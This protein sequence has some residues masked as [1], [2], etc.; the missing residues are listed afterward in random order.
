MKN[1]S[2][3]LAFVA[4]STFAGAQNI[5]HPW[6]VSAGSNF[7]DFHFVKKP[8]TEQIRDAN[9][10]GKKAPT[11]LRVGRLVKPWLSVSATY[12]TVTLEPGRLNAIPLDSVITDDYFVKAGIQAEYR[13]AN[14]SLLK[15][16]SFFDPYIFA[17]FTATWIND[18]FYPGIPM[19]FGINLWPVDFLGVNFQASYDYLFD[20]NDYAHYALG[21]TF[22]FGNMIDK[23]NDRVADRYD[24]CPEIWGLESMHG[25]PDYDHDGVVDS[26]DRC[27]KEYGSA[28]ADG[29]PD[30]DKDGI[31][32][33]E[34]ACTCEAGPKSRNGCPENM[35]PKQE[36]KAPELLE[37]PVETTPDKTEQNSDAP[38]QMQQET[39]T[40]V[41]VPEETT[42][43]ATIDE[44]IDRHLDNIHFEANSAAIKPSSYPSL[45][46]I[47]MIMRQNPE[48]E[49]TI[50][51]YTDN[52]GPTDYNLFLSEIRA[53]SVKEYFT[54]KGVDPDR[55]EAKGF[56][57]IDDIHSNRTREGRAKN[58]RVEI[59]MK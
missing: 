50:Q 10:M 20:F 46:E 52:S 36:T 8:F 22:R 57:E 56:G 28:V 24:A 17:G 13:F 9:W 15:D 23:D 4:L 32:D 51:G 41:I 14:G 53:K 27:P 7:T 45:D 6:V 19:G 29:C 2:F 34:D 49:F 26:L 25:C 48:K 33:K 12:A 43:P 31:A 47:L 3:F 42:E 11:M 59:Y 58:R 38:V 18:E 35:E 55:L 40:K 39:P 21:L 1:F 30:F 5:Y 54:K 16:E 37:S 44:A